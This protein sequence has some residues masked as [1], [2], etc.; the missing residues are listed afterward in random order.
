[1]KTFARPIS[2]GIVACLLA[3]IAAAVALA[4]TEAAGGGSLVAAASMTRCGGLVTSS[5]CVVS[6]VGAKRGAKRCPA[7]SKGRSCRA[8]SV[9]VGDAEE[10]R[11]VR[12]AYLKHVLAS[13][14]RASVTYVESGRLAK[15]L[16]VL[17][18]RQTEAEARQIASLRKLA[19]TDP[20]STLV[21]K[22]LEATEAKLV[23]ARR[24]Y[25]DSA[26][27]EAE[28]VVPGAKGDFCTLNV[29][30]REISRLGCSKIGTGVER[31][32]M[33]GMTVVKG[34]YELGGLLPRGATRF[35]VVDSKH[36]VY[37][38]SPSRWGGFEIAGKGAMS[39]LEA[40]TRSGRWRV[41]VNTRF[42][43]LAAARH[44][45]SSSR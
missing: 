12:P 41:I 15:A 28:Y 44:S 34:G 25:F 43:P 24:F 30:G 23:H 2:A 5:T 16:P 37:E 36:D 10:L 1:M 6:L 9:F 39:R 27:G 14:R 22:V 8:V 11:L 7:S 17:R 4:N 19:A 3:S 20:S 29:K 26:S 45:S 42:P 13:L 18:K 35:R 31:N 33:I 40:Q 21:K 32:G 38:G